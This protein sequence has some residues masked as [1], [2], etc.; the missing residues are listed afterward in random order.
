MER[1]H[2]SLIGN[3]LMVVGLVLSI[4]SLLIALL[5]QAEGSI[6]TDSWAT[7]S[8][9]GIFLGAFFWLMGAQLSG[10]EKVCE[11]Y[12]LLRF[13]QRHPHRRRHS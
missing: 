12:Y 2:T 8:V 5:S 1:V 11:K 6:F 7:G 3:A 9:L 10:R 13:H 4:S